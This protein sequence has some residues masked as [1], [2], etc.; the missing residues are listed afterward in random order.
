MRSCCLTEAKIPP[1]KAP[2]VHASGSNEPQQSYLGAG[3][4]HAKWTV[5][6]LIKEINAPELE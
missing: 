5:F 6:K 2:N 4:G 1:I 3:L